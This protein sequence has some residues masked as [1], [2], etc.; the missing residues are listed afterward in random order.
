MTFYP[1]MTRLPEG[2]GPKLV[3]VPF[4]LTAPVEIPKEGAEGVIFAVGGDAGGL[5]AF[6]VGGK[7]EVPLQL[8]RHQTL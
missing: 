5:L 6:P 3:G 2:S 7:G 1:G 4:T 8:L